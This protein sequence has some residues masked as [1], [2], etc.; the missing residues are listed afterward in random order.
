MSSASAQRRDRSLRVPL[1]AVF[2]VLVGLLHPSPAQARDDSQ[3]RPWARGTTAI[4]LG[5]GVAS[6]RD[7]VVWSGSLSGA[8]YVFDGVAAGLEVDETYLA[9]RSNARAQH[10][11]WTDTIP[12]NLVS[13][14]PT[15]RIVPFRSQRFSPFVMAGVGPMIINRG[16]G[17]V[18]RWVIMPGAYIGLGRHA[19]LGLSVRFTDDFP[20]DRCEE[21]FSHANSDGSVSRVEGFCGFRWAPQ[22]GLGFVF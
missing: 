18:G 20:P 22:V 8:Y 21:A 6:S 19:Y 5:L 3:G 9:W 13:V 11:E 1:G 15:M 12:T 7:V 16:G 2:M 17:V 10:P 14:T 4:G